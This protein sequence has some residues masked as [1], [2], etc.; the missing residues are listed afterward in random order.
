MTTIKLIQYIFCQYICQFSLDL[1]NEQTK[2]PWCSNDKYDLNTRINLLFFFSS[3]KALAISTFQLS[4][5][6]KR[7]NFVFELMSNTKHDI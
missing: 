3:L 7:K 2:N 1:L 4:M 6:R 5:N